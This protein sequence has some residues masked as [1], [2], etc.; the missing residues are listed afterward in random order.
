MAME[1]LKNHAIQKDEMTASHLRNQLDGIVVELTDNP[2]DVDD[3]F[4]AVEALY[5]RTGC[6]LSNNDNKNK[7]VKLRCK[8][9]ANHLWTTGV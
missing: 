9:Q 1:N 8:W 5:T 6:M 2:Y 3:K 7:L 4:V